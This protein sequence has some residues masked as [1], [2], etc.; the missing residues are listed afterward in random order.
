MVVIAMTIPTG[1]RCFRFPAPSYFKSLMPIVW[2]LQLQGHVQRRAM[3]LGAVFGR[4]TS[5]HACVVSSYAP[6]LQVVAMNTGRVC[7]ATRHRQELLVASVHRR[8]CLSE[9]VQV[10]CDGIRFEDAEAPEL[11]TRRKLSPIEVLSFHCFSI[12]PASV[13]STCT[14]RVSTDT[15]TRRRD[16]GK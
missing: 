16:A 12:S 11:S 7:P 3:Q 9:C 6:H 15:R 1:D 13:I 8:L 4:G 2:V 5:P 14:S 10:P